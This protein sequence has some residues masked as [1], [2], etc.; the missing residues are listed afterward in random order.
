M[1]KVRKGKK[2]LIILLIAI[3]AI[4]A[5]VVIVNIKKKQQTPSEPEAESE[6]IPLPETTY[7]EM[8]VKNVQMEYL[9]DNNE[10]EI[11]M[12]IHNT[13]SNKIDKE[14][15]DVVW[16]G[17][18]EET[19]AKINTQIKDLDVGEQHNLSVILPGNLT[20]T[21]EIKLIEK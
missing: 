11:K 19:L 9:K 20:K 4:I 16:I 3:V 6:I 21:K 7:S 10:T 5:T 1:K 8:E 13:T 17:P 12:E 14:K 18:N 2:M 15:F